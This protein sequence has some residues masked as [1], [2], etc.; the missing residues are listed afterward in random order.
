MNARHGISSRM[1]T[2]AGLV[3]MIY[4]V[5]EELMEDEEKF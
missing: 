1:A 5:R 3:Q 4:T 2:F